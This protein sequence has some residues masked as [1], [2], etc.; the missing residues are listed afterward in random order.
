MA[1]NLIANLEA[2]ACRVMEFI[3]VKES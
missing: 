1:A 2:G 3:F